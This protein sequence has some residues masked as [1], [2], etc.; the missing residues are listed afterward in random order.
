MQEG[1][2]KPLWL[3][4]KI[5]KKSDENMSVLTNKLEAI[6]NIFKTAG[7]ATA[8][9]K[10]ILYG[11]TAY[12]GST[13][14]TG[15]MPNRGQQN[16]TLNCGNTYTIPEGYHDGTGVV[17]ANS[18]ASQTAV[19]ADKAA[20]TASSMLEGRQAWVNGNKVSGTMANKASTTVTTTDVTISSDGTYIGIPATGYY[21]TNSLVKADNSLFIPGVKITKLYSHGYYQT[22]STIAESY[23]LKADYDFVIATSWAAFDFHDDKDGTFESQVANT[24]TFSG[25]AKKIIGESGILVIKDAK[26]GCVIKSSRMRN[27]EDVDSFIMLTVVGIKFGA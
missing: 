17:S 26:N 25:T 15:S 6:Q 8:E 2:D 7:S 21:N 19:D 27:R 18:L 23:K 11:K 13:L 14:L 24:P 1:W 20:V 12:N 16:K 4:K 9:G 5:F 10:D 22:I 3:L